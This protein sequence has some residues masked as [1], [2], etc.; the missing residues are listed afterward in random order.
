MTRRGLLMVGFQATI[1]LVVVGAFGTAGFLEYSAQPGFCDNCHYMQPYYQSWLTSSHNFVPCIKCHYAPGIKAEAMSKVQA[2]NQV[3]KYITGT[4]REKPWAEIEDAACTRSGCHLPQEL[5]AVSFAGVRFD[6]EEHLGEQRRGKQL[7]CTSCHSQI[8]QGE[9]VTVTVSTCYLCHFKDQP[10]GQPIGGCLSCHPTPPD[11]QYQG[12]RVDHAEIV[13]NLVSCVK[14]HENVVVGDGAVIEERCW[15]CHNVPQRVAQIGDTTLIHRVHIAEHNVECQQCHTPIQHKIVA[16]K[17]TFELDCKACHAGAHAA[18]RMLFSGSG[19]HGV[20][21]TPSKMF[22]ARVSCESCHALPAAL[23]GHEG[24]AVAGEA[25]CLSCHGVRYANMLPQWQAELQRRLGLA[26][27]VVRSARGAVPRGSVPRADTLL[28]AAVANVELVRVGRGAHNVEYADQ[29]LRKAVELARQAVSASGSGAKLPAV[30]LGPPVAENACLSCHVG[31]EERDPLSWR[32]RR[33]V[34]GSHTVRAGLSC[35]ACHTPLEQHGGLT[36]SGSRACEQCHHTAVPPQRCA[37]CHGGAPADTFRVE[38]GTFIHEP[39]VQ[40][41]IQCTRCHVPPAVD[42][43]RTNCATCH[44]FHHSP[45]ASCRVCHRE[46]PKTRH[47]RGVHQVQC[48]ACHR[49]APVRMVNRWTREVC[50]V[51]HQDLAEHN[52]PAECTACHEIPSPWAGGR[53]PAAPPPAGP[54]PEPRGG[55]D[56]RQPMRLAPSAFPA[57]RGAP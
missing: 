55:A 6:H 18:Q 11:T 27:R 56:L 24:V 9:H 19:G 48:Q 33:F 42:A 13:R 7:R 43:R 14:C 35:T 50:L 39:H 54:F 41:G 2:A 8:V 57:A 10:P 52:A 22:L 15:T 16:L 53:V 37:S 26:E 36:L 44:V 28:D 31:V 17:E 51:C 3:V 40:S 46:S 49:T 30:D 4:Y 38:A 32:G 29:L 21:E 20:P 1:V 34:H 5:G 23:P 25:T 47:P 45:S 12:V